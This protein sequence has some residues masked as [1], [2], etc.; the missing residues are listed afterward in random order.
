MQHHVDEFSVTD[1]RHTLSEGWRVVSERRWWFAVPFCVTATVAFIASHFVPRQYTTTMVFRRQND[2]ILDGALADHWSTLY[3]EQRKRLGKD[4]MRPGLI[5]EVLRKLDPIAR[6]DEPPASPA[7]T[8]GPNAGPSGPRD[9]ARVKQVIQGLSVE[10]LEKTHNSDLARL[11]LTLAD[12]T[13]APRILEGILEQYA[14]TMRQETRDA[15]LGARGFYREREAK[16]RAAWTNL[17][18]QIREFEREYPGIN[19]SLPDPT[20]S[21]REQLLHTRTEQQERIDEAMVRRDQLIRRLERLGAPGPELQS[22]PSSAR[23]PLDDPSLKPNPRYATLRQ[24]IETLRGELAD[25]L[26]IRRMTEQH[27]AIIGLRA[28]LQRRSEQFAATPPRIPADEVG[29]SGSLAGVVVTEEERLN[30]QIADLGT[31]IS[32]HE[33]RL[34]EAERQIKGSRRL[35]NAIFKHRDEYHRLVES[36]TAVRSELTAWQAQLVPLRNALTVENSDRGV[37]FAVTQKPFK[38]VRPSAPGVLTLLVT[39]LGLAA[40]VGVVFGLMKELVDR[41][42]RTTKQ[43]STALGIPVIESVD[44]IISPAM[45]K[46]RLIRQLMVLPALTLVLAGTTLASG[47]LAYLSIE[48]PARYEEVKAQPKRVVQQVFGRG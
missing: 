14:L 13:R 39:C 47:A 16:T 37:H 20:A 23:F 7:G 2:P 9:L 27:P 15:L 40:A 45:R 6:E 36:A 44:E 41:S 8:G 31:R 32:A 43:V 3:T 29:S 18:Q 1:I 46:R 26:K 21:N 4:L 30:V 34:A 25:D 10:L 48:N 38:A 17:T 19:S 11:S 35:R 12:P 24:E 42:F 33:S 5:S 22:A 28:R